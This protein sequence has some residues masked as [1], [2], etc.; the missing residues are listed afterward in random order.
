MIR[1]LRRKPTTVSALF[2][3]SCWMVECYPHDITGDV[4]FGHLDKVVS[5]ILFELSLYLGN[6]YNLQRN[7]GTLMFQ[8]EKSFCLGRNNSNNFAT[9][10]SAP[11]SLISKQHGQSCILC[12]VT[13]H[14]S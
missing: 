1:V 9:L 6:L 8:L 3:T 12:A 13:F 7:I 10:L 4:N 2:T 5:D 14:I 11:N